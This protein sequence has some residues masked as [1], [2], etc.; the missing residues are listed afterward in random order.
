M[1]IL[2]LKNSD[3]NEFCTQDTTFGNITKGKSHLFQIGKTRQ[4]IKSTSIS[5]V[6]H[7]LMVIRTNRFP[8]LSLLS[9]FHDPIIQF[10]SEI[11][12]FYQSV[13][14]LIFCKIVI[15]LRRILTAQTLRINQ[16]L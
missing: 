2:G 8:S 13:L 6:N 9:S 1:V 4:Q 3:R 16:V 7:A 14:Q 10:T 11:P 5:K 12:Q 15:I